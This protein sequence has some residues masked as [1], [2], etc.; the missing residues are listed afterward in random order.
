MLAVYIDPGQGK[1]KISPYLAFG[2]RMKEKVTK[3]TRVGQNNLCLIFIGIALGL[4]ALSIVLF[5]TIRTEVL[6][7][8]DQGQ[9][10]VHVDLSAGSRIEAT[11]EVIKVVETE[12]AEIEEVEDVSVTIGSST[13]TRVGE[14]EAE[15]LRSHQGYKSCLD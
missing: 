9:F 6:P 2:A 11:D 15:S 7:K 13:S 5:K 1:K 8:I 3:M 12:A 10:L 14:V 4:F